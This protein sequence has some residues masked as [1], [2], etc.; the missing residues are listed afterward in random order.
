MDRTLVVIGVVAGLGGLAF[1]GY[2]LYRDA[3]RSS[4][5]TLP[6]PPVSQM[7][8]QTQPNPNNVQP[9]AAQPPAAKP[10]DFFADTLPGLVKGFS[11][12]LGPLENI[13]GK[14]A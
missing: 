3:K 11:D 7:L 6:P 14:F 9:P 12:I 10:P 5:P 8:P 13:F 4:A 2:Q 1:A